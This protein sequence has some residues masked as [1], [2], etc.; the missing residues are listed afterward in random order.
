MFLQTCNTYLWQVKKLTDEF[1][2]EYN[3]RRPHQSLNNMTPKEYLL[4]CGQLAYP[5]APDDLTTV[6]QVINNN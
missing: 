1:V 4:K 5:P 2:D 3:N 6:Q